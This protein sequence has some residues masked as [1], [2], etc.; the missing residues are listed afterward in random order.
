VRIFHR[1]R[2][3]DISSYLKEISSSIAWQGRRSEEK[4]KQGGGTPPEDFPLEETTST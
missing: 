4:E 3:E 2:K 1:E